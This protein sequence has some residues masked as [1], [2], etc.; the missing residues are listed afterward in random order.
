MSTLIKSLNL[1]AK[2]LVGNTPLVKIRYKY[3]GVPQHLFAKL[4]YYNLSGSIK[5]RLAAHTIHRSYELGI[6]K[7]G[8]VIVEATSG[9]TGVAFA[10]IGAM[11]G[12][13]VTIYMPDWMS[14]ER[15]ALIKSYGAKINLISRADGGFFKCIEITKRLKAE[16]SNVFLPSQFDNTLNVEAHYQTTGPEIYNQL[17]NVGQRLD[18]FVAGVGT[19][20]TIMGVAQYLKEQDASIKVHP[21]EPS[22]SPILTNGYKSGSHRI[23][24]ISDDFIPDIVELDQL[25]EIVSVDD[26]DSIIMAQKI[27]TDLGLG[28]G[29]SSGA[30]FIGVIKAKQ[31]L[32]IDA[33]VVTIFCD[34]S[35]KYL[36]TDL[37]KVEPIKQDFVS[38]DVVLDG[39]EFI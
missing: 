23:Q 2:G 35:K 19:G 30:N 27:A 5:D 20:G 7:P 6:I 28:V 14:K 36:S 18:A 8:D 34:C 4:E 38:T 25:N 33:N 9:N 29:I 31:S 11:Y 13:P 32:V 17:K 3:K 12:H 39:F 15:I 16:N 37:A 24:G 21:L 1:T 22:N 26:G 10:A